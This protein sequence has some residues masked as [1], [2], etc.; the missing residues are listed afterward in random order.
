MAEMDNNGQDQADPHSY[1]WYWRLM[2]YFG[3][4]THPL[5]MEDGGEEDRGGLA[6]PSKWLQELLKLPDDRKTR[7]QIFQQ[8]EPFD[9]VSSILDVY[10][11]EMTQPDYEKKRSLWLD[12]KHAHMITSGDVCLQNIMFE[13][14]AFGIARQMCT[15]GD[16][17]RRNVYQT[18]KGILGWRFAD[19]ATVYRVE[20]KYD[21]LLGFR[22]DGQTKFRISKKSNVSY[23]WDYVHFRLIGKDTRTQYGS[24]I[25]GAM[26]RPWRQ[27]ALLEDSDITYNLRRAADRSLVLVDTGDLDEIDSGE[28]LRRFERRMK[29]HV[30]ID[31]A[32]NAYRKDYNP[33]TPIEDVFM[34]LR[35]P[36]DATRIES[37]AGNQGASLDPARIDYYRNKLFGASKVPKAYLGFEGEI[38][39][40]A[41]LMQQD[42]RF[43]RTLKRG[44][45][46]L[47]Y[48]MRNTLDIHYMLYAE[49]P[50]EN[51]YNIHENP[52]VI[53]MSPI[54]Y[55][56][57]MERLELVQ[58]R[59][60][61]VEAMAGLGQILQIDAS[62]WATYIL[63]HYAKLPENVVTLLMRKGDTPTVPG[64]PLNGA[65]PMPG[66]S[67]FPEAVRSLRG[68]REI[69]LE[70]EKR[71]GQA[72]QNSQWRAGY[73][74][75]SDSEQR[76]IAEAI[77][78]SPMLRGVIANIAEYHE[79]D[80]DQADMQTD[81]TLLPSQFIEEGTG[82]AVFLEDSIEEDDET[83][84][85]REEVQALMGK[86][87]KPEV[88]VE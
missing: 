75:F 40:K 63:I 56:D 81:L 61:L 29:R 30:F 49:N 22:Q 16:D 54:A 78:S 17:L 57:E 10:A 88:I 13:D 45:K 62:A 11:E 35:G 85:L 32:S 48:G 52:Y 6:N 19:P 7:Y 39:A 65:P 74:V 71:I 82:K 38:D 9:L 2:D 87:A 77:H 46:A 44:Q 76:Q 36:D 28:R 25:L 31:P 51:Q 1:P 50:A 43:A 5:G 33:L 23:A 12:S 41:T 69:L 60:S 34:A 18:G 86:S 37:M 80:F 20:D 27:L 26:F 47:I 66:A 8:M 58:L 15:L 64:A 55:L 84:R 24:S 68:K 83:R 70:R 53:M 59:Y 67:P 42:V 4:T 14:R 3:L 72:A 79:E 21:R 73:G